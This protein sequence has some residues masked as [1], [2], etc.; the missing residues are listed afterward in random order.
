M[1]K[2]TVKYMKRVGGSA[3][4]CSVPLC[5]ASASVC[6]VSFHTFPVDAELRAKWLVNI[7][8]DDFIVTSKSKVCGRHF[9]P[10]DVVTTAGGYHRIRKGAVPVL[11]EWNGYDVRQRASVWERRERPVAYC[12][13]QTENDDTGVVEGNWSDLL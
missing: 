7:K 11:F 3:E 13:D 6:S 10:E 5:S 4:F 1:K 12:T 9:L 8:R 2:G